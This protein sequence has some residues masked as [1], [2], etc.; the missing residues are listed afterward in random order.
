MKTERILWLGAVISALVLGVLGGMSF[1]K[2]KPAEASLDQRSI[3]FES[4]G[5]G[6]AHLGEQTFAGEGAAFTR[7]REAFESVQLVQKNPEAALRQAYRIKNELQRLD[8]FYQIFEVWAETDPEAALAYI[9]ENPHAGGIN[10]DRRLGGLVAGLVRTNPEKAF[11]LVIERNRKTSEPYRLYDSLFRSIV[12][13]GKIRLAI[14]KLALFENDNDDLFTAYRSLGW[15][16]SQTDPQAAVSWADTLDGRRSRYVKGG[17]LKFWPEHD[18]AG[19]AEYTLQE[20][21]GKR[22]LSQIISKWAKMDIEG[23]SNWLLR[24]EPGE[25]LDE[26]ARTMASLAKEDYPEKAKGWA[27]SITDEKMRAETIKSIDAFHADK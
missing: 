20:M 13:S 21:G 10:Y 3:T 12:D 24:H 4:A 7:Q 17:I 25:A 27:N 14:D 22:E 5:A 11:Q 9:D 23:A 8:R 26:A 19:A 15:A 16:W 1:N 2:A 6:T 18:P